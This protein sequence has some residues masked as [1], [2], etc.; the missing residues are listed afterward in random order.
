MTIPMETG[1]PLLPAPTRA[2]WQRSPLSAG[3][4]GMWL[5]GIL[6]G[7]G[8]DPDSLRRVGAHLCK[9]TCLSSC[10]KNK[11]PIDVRRALGYHSTPGDKTALVYSRDSIAGPLCFLQDTIDQVSAGTFKPDCTRSG[12]HVAASASEV[13]GETSAERFLR[14]Q[15]DADDDGHEAVE[16]EELETD[17]SSEDSADEEF[18]EHDLSLAA[19]AE[20]E[21]VPAWSQF[22]ADVHENVVDAKLVRHRQSTMYHL[23]ADEGG[24][25]LK[26][27]RTITSNFDV[28]MDET[29]FVYPMCTTC[30]GTR[31]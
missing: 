8:E 7:L 29:K 19:S 12:Y 28:V 24:T 16:S 1:Y 25:H 13:P 4:A 6:L 18:Q 9:A 30:F 22:E 26:C 14:L 20:N 5:R 17:S 23:I 3:Q 15:G 2:G 10:S 31:R 27:G 11:V 21:V